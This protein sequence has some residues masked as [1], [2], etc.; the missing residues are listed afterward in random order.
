MCL[1][2]PLSVDKY[3]SYG[4]VH[5]H[6]QRQVL[7]WAVGFINY[8][9]ETC[10]LFSLFSYDCQCYCLLVKR[11]WHW[12]QCILFTMAMCQDFLYSSDISTNP[13]TTTNITAI[14]KNGK[15]AYN[16]DAE[17]FKCI[18]FRHRHVAVNRTQKGSLSNCNNTWNITFWF[19]PFF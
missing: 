12:F 5:K 6:F 18:L 2:D 14:L 19:K 1:Q 13:S 3:T 8:C 17:L 9:V 4:E 16:L 10:T 7:D 11:D 15:A